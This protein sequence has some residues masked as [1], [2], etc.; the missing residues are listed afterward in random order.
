M[1]RR[2]LTRKTV[3]LWMLS[4]LPLYATY[5]E[6]T[7]IMSGDIAL[8]SSADKE[9]KIAQRQFFI[10]L[11]LI[12]KTSSHPII[13]VFSVDKYNRGDCV[14]EEKRSIE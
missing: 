7:T 13:F 3:L 1:H 2:S 9:E 11:S 12:H 6:I 5:L 4:L 14:L 10:C 8:P